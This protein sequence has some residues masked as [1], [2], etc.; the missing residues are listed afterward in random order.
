[1]RAGD[2]NR[3]IVLR[4]A[5]NATDD[6]G[7]RI[8]IWATLATVWAE[9]L[10]LS[11]GERVRAAQMGATATDRFRILKGGTWADINAQDQLVFAGRAYAIDGVKPIENGVGLEITATARSDG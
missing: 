4:R 11:D 1:M 5:A 9:H 3:R 10:P 6:Y 2:R 7:G 8:T